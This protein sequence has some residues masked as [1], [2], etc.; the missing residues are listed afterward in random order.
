MVR[1]PPAPISSW[2][3][4]SAVP[5]SGVT[6]A[7]TRSLMR[8]KASSQSVCVSWSGW[9]GRGVRVDAP[10]TPAPSLD[11]DRDQVGLLHRPH[12]LDQL[13]HRDVVW[14]LDA[15]HDQALSEVVADLRAVVKIHLFKRF[16]DVIKAPQR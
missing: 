5:A 2:S 3:R 14:V 13:R 7:R 11:D 4:P 1:S 10:P 8:R 6:T 16:E 15:E 12:L 9:G